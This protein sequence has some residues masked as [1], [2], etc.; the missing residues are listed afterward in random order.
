MWELVKNSLS[1]DS[2]VSS[3]RLITMISVLVSVAVNVGIILLS[4][5]IALNPNVNNV[6]A[7]Q[8]LD[9]MIKLTVI[10]STLVLL[11]I[12]VI[13]WQNINETARTIRGLPG[14]IGEV[15]ATVK[16]KLSEQNVE[17]VIEGHE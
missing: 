11:L 6:A 1:G 14:M 17:P 12:G 16:A 7:I 15:E 2:S 4:F 9:R 13:T 8:A 10:N 5:R 3:R